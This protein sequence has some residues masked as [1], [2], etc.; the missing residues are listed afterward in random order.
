MFNPPPTQFFLNRKVIKL[1]FINYHAFKKSWL[2]V[3]DDS[4][5]VELTTG[6]GFPDIR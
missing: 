4:V 2:K 5:D 6:A 1:K 3:E